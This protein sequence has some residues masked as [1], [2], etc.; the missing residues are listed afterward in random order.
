MQDTIENRRKVGLVS[1]MQ[2]ALMSVRDNGILWFIFVSSYYVG[3]ITARFG[4]EKAD[5]LR[6]K[7]TC[8]ALIAQLQTS[9]SG[10]TG[11]GAARATSGR[12][13]W[14]GRI[15]LSETLSPAISINAAR[16]WKSGLVQGGGPSFWSRRQAR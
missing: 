1:K 10:K 8:P 14:N 7:K 15:L 6:R 9:S 13:V 3:S 2:L 11:I 16:W 12:L 4:L 5:A